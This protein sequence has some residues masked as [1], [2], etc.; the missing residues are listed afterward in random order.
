VPA[1]EK[2]ADFSTSA[3]ASCS[4]SP[5]SSCRIGSLTLEVSHRGAAASRQQQQLQAPVASAPPSA[6]PP[7][8][9]RAAPTVDEDADTDA[10]DADALTPSATGL[11]AEPTSV[12]AETGDTLAPLS[13]PARAGGRGHA[14]VQH[15]QHQQQQQQQGP[16]TPFVGCGLE[17]KPPLASPDASGAVDSGYVGNSSRA[18]A[19]AAAAAA[20][21][22]G[23]DSAAVAF[24][25]FTD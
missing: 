16:W 19:A 23:I 15:T 20:R 1:S 22:S 25:G 2:H 5:D 9:A 13:S 18:A 3:G 21:V 6:K 17:P 4:A 10:Y 8:P 24:H 11:A 7:A 14:D 12:G